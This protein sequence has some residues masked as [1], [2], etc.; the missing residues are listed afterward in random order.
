MDEKIEI[1]MWKK[2]HTKL[3]ICKRKEKKKARTT[4]LKTYKYEGI[5]SK[6]GGRIEYLQGRIEDL[7][8]R[9]EERDEGRSVKE[10]CGFEWLETKK[11]FVLWLNLEVYPV[12]IVSIV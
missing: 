4:Q 3:R 2:H 9:R 12:C 11:L 1:M 5:L 8:G 10:S 6:G 7:Q